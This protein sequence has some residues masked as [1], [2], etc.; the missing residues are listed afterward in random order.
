MIIFIIIN[1]FNRNGV[2]NW[3]RLRVKLNWELLRFNFN[4]IIINGMIIKYPHD[5]WNHRA[6][7][8]RRGYGFEVRLWR[9]DVTLSWR[10]IWFFTMKG[11]ETIHISF[12]TC[13]EEFR[14]TDDAG[15][16]LV[17]NPSTSFENILLFHVE[18]CNNWLEICCIIVDGILSTEMMISLNWS[19]KYCWSSNH[20]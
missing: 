6:G 14:A 11:I 17:C 12:K 15:I 18:S 7:V 3:N 16:S 4:I 19:G 10:F 9:L 1:W 13:W 20:F 8:G 5:S 2:W